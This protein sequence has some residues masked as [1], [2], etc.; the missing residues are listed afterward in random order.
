VDFQN[1]LNEKRS[2]VESYLRTIFSD[3]VSAPETLKR[4]ME[5]SLFSEEEDQPILT[6]A[7]CAAGNGTVPAALPF[8]WL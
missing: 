6:L 1:Y 8:A 7:T 5:H 3:F 2:A 4:A